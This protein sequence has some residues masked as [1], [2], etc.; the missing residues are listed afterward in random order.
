MGAAAAKGVVIKGKKE[1]LLSIP[2]SALTGKM[3]VYQHCETGECMVL[4]DQDMS[5]V[6][7]ITDKSMWMRLDLS[8]KQN[9]YMQGLTS[10]VTYPVPMEYKEGETITKRTEPSP[11]INVYGQNGGNTLVQA[12]TKVART[13]EGQKRDVDDGTVSV[14]I[15]LDAVNVILRPLMLALSQQNHLEMSASLMR[16]VAAFDAQMNMENRSLQLMKMVLDLSTE[17]Y[18]AKTIKTLE[19]DIVHAIE[20]YSIVPPPVTVAGVSTQ[21]AQ[22]T[23]GLEGLQLALD[24]LRVKK[25]ILR[26]YFSP[27]LSINDFKCLRILNEGAFAKVYQAVK[28]KDKTHMNYAI[29]VMEKKFIK[30]QNMVKRIK[31]ECK[32]MKSTGSNREMFV[33]L[34]CSLQSRNY[35]YIVME[36]VRGGDFLT[37]L[38][39]YGRFNEATARFYIAELCIAVAYLHDHGVVHRDIKLDNILLTDRGHLKLMD[40][41]MITPSNSLLERK[42]NLISDGGGDDGWI[43]SLSFTQVGNRGED[44]SSASFNYTDST[45]QLKS[46]VG[47]YH[48]ASPEVIL[49]LGYDHAVDWWSVGIL[50]F[51]FLTGTTPFMAKTAE[52]TVDNIAEYRVNWRVMPDNVSQ[53]ARNLLNGL[54]AYNAK[55]RLGSARSEDVLN[56]PYFNGINFDTLY[57]QPGPLLPAGLDAADL[58]NYDGEELKEDFMTDPPEAKNDEF[59]SF[60]MENM[61]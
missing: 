34:Y 8:R 44:V 51:Q 56:H 18:D 55:D 10:S 47:N 43:E 48:Y 32:V 9:T 60:C 41:G 61:P 7:G 4:V 17:N 6:D 38:A 31:R 23:K 29:K 1:D 12:D 2:L 52:R 49:E 19:S 22:Q 5:N 33:R 24:K 54:L 13:T 59:E 46:V 11:L 26:E 40:F 3:R 25:N 35:L 37:Q 39:K 36:Y 15:N 30:Q 21:S 57:D 14:K 53:E 27:Q 58:V 42:G 45:G 20:M 16:A 50:F 28:K